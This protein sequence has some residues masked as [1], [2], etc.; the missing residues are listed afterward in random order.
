LAGNS[1][2]GP[3]PRKKTRSINGLMRDAVRASRDGQR[4][5]TAMQH[6]FR[7]KWATHFRIVETYFKQLI[8]RKNICGALRMS[9]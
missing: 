7:P 8:L 4:G 1:P 5:L 9:A 3:R 2:L 6:S